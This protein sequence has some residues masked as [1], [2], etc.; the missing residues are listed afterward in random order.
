MLYIYTKK[1]N[2]STLN[3]YDIQN[4]LLNSFLHACQE[5]QILFAMSMVST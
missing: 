2:L 3:S 5:T 4:D 1:L